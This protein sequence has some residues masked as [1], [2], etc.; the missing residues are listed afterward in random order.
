MQRVTF[1]PTMVWF[2]RVG[3]RAL[4][5]VPKLLSIPLWSDFIVLYRGHE[6]TV[7]PGFQSHYGLI[8]SQAWKETGD[9]WPATFNPTMVWFY[10][11]I[12]KVTKAILLD[13][14]FQ[15]HYGLILSKEQKERSSKDWSTFNPTMVWFYLG[16]YALWSQPL[17]PLLSIPLWSDFILLRI[18]KQ[19][20]VC[21]PSKHDNKND[22]QSHYGL[23]L[24]GTERPYRSLHF[25]T[26]NPTMVWFYP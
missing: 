25:W 15:S 14:D 11:F 10:H 22:F 17:L 1:N 8:L 21:L 23:I 9:I 18:A 26:F 4:F 13:V 12:C 16:D 3:V 5:P 6:H 24:S 19:L 2:Y 20:G 7:I